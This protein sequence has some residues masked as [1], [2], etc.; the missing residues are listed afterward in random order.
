M[1]VDVEFWSGQDAIEQLVT[2][3]LKMSVVNL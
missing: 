1:D 2:E 3:M